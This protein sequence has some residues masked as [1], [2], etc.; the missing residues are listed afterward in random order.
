[1]ADAYA[2]WS[3]NDFYGVVYLNSTLQRPPQTVAA[4]DPR[5]LG[6]KLSVWN[7]DPRAETIEVLTS[8]VSERLKVLAQKTWNSEPLVPSYGAFLS[9]GE[10]IGDA[11][12]NARGRIGH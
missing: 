8:E 3:V 4:G 1:M 2:K 11:P 12:G 10:A 9:L 6:A 7:D 5:N